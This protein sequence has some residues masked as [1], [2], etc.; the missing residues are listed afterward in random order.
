MII[1]NAGQLPRQIQVV[2][3]E[4]GEDYFRKESKVSAAPQ[5][6]LNSIPWNRSLLSFF[7]FYHSIRQRARSIKKLG[8]ERRAARREDSMQEAEDQFREWH[9]V[10]GA[11][12]QSVPVQEAMLRLGHHAE[13]VLQIGGLGQVHAVL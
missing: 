6:L 3:R 11:R 12:V 8:H 1:I 10:R 5:S 2:L 13:R 4:G 7:L 9:A